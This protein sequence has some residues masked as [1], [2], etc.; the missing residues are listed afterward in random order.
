MQVFDSPPSF[1]RLRSRWA[2]VLL[3]GTLIASPASADIY[4]WVDAQGSVHFT[5]DPASVPATHRQEA[6][7]VDVA[8]RDSRV[9][10]VERNSSVPTA[11]RSSSGRHVVSLERAGLQMQVRALLNDSLEARFVVDT[12]AMM[13]SIPRSLVEKLGITIDARTPRVAVSGIT[14]KAQLAPVVTLRN[15]KLGGAVVEQI[16]MVVLD[17]LD[18]GLLGMSFFNHFRVQTDPVR[19]TLTLEEISEERNVG[20]SVLDYQFSWDA[21]DGASR[22]FLEI[23]NDDSFERVVDKVWVSGTSADLQNLDVDLTT[24][25]TYFWR[26]AAVDDAGSRGPWSAPHDFRYR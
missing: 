11:S 4:R 23:S 25:G 24:P 13:N 9:N 19:G 15:L 2:A 12:G 1:P 14:A 17:T 3:L 22:Y 10:V 16:E 5:D 21:V 7:S 26:V 20:D 8:A 6:R 18:V